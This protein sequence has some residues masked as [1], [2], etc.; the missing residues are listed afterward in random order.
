MCRWFCR[1]L[2]LYSETGLHIGMERNFVCS[3][4]RP[5]CRSQVIHL[6]LSALIS[7]FMKSITGFLNNFN[8]HAIISTSLINKFTLSLKNLFSCFR[9]NIKRFCSSLVSR[10]NFSQSFTYTPYLFYK[11]APNQRSILSVYGPWPRNVGVD[12][13]C[14]IPCDVVGVDE[15]EESLWEG[16]GV[17]DEG[18]ELAVRRLARQDVQILAQ[19]QPPFLAQRHKILSK[20][21]QSFQAFSL[22]RF[23]L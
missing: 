9:R 20:L 12:T 21:K 7:W 11:N 4:R 19:L 2:G 23:A 18:G 15:G 1:N 6:S 17:A 8:F 13:S 10:F 3:W 5:N 14:C 16:E 22:G